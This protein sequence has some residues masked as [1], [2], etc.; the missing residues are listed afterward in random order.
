MTTPALA[1][2]R[3]LWKTLRSFP[4]AEKVP[5][6]VSALGEH[7][8][9]LAEEKSPPEMSAPLNEALVAVKDLQPAEVDLLLAM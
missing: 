2:L 5:A 3:A 1:I 8:L 7:L 6:L 9:L 4:D